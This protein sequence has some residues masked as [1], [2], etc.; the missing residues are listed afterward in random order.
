MF[1]KLKEWMDEH[2]TGIAQ[3]VVSTVVLGYLG[4]IGYSVKTSMQNEKEEHEARLA[5]YANG[6]HLNP[7]IKFS[8]DDRPI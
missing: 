6:I 7:E 4:L 8:D 1:K 2:Q 5:M 3:A